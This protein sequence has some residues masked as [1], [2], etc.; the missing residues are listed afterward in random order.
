M[1]ADLYDVLEVP[2]A[3]SQ[4]QIKSAYRRLARAYHPDTNPDP[5]AAVRF[6]AVAQA[7]AVLSDMARRHAYDR[8]GEVEPG[9]AVREDGDESAFE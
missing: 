6:K 7:Y 3:A 5:A 9:R 1:S 8:T 2:R 4:R